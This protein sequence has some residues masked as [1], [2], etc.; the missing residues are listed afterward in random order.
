M[1]KLA[2]FPVNN[3]TNSNMYEYILENIINKNGNDKIK[4]SIKGNM[5]CFFNI[6]IIIPLPNF[7]MQPISYKIPNRLLK[8]I[9]LGVNISFLKNIYKHIN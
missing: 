3:I 6:W 9:C 1:V 8:K 4:H 5:Y 2:S 7:S